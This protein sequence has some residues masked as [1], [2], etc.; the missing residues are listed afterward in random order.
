MSKRSFNRHVMYC[1]ILIP[2]SLDL[3]LDGICERVLWNLHETRLML[4]IQ[5]HLFQLDGGISFAI[6]G[7]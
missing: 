5:N 3:A 4:A 1:L 6:S 2:T 7:P